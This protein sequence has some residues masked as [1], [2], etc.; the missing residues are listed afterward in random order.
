[1]LQHSCSLSSVFDLYP[2]F[3]VRGQAPRPP[4]M[5]CP[6][7][8]CQSSCPD[9]AHPFFCLLPFTSLAFAT[10]PIIPLKSLE[11]TFS[12]FF[13][14]MRKKKFKIFDAATKKN[15]MLLLSCGYFRY[16]KQQLK[17]LCSRLHFQQPCSSSSSTDHNHLFSATKKDECGD[18][19]AYCW[20]PNS[21]IWAK[22]HFSLMRKD[23]DTGCHETSTVKHASV[24]C[25]FP[26]V[27]K[28]KS[29]AVRRSVKLWNKWQS[30]SLL[31]SF[32]LVH[33]LVR[34]I[35]WEREREGNIFLA[36]NPRRLQIHISTGGAL[37]AHYSTMAVQGQEESSGLN[38][39][40]LT[41]TNLA[42]ASCR[43]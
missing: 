19:G 34:L 39:K 35:L 7:P 2:L 25:R 37:W 22:T 4:L 43:I 20:E 8:G 16:F 36:I 11:M 12:F 18:S 31:S 42:A 29:E 5:Y 27:R 3:R 21:C 38:Q 24:E 6:L 30:R 1:M 15:T 23:M 32:S 41:A 10:P 28:K 26:H 17:S 14:F 33:E 9:A 13:N 40:T